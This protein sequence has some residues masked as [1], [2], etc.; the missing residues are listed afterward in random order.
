MR[1]PDFICTTMIQTTPC[2]ETSNKTAMLLAARGYRSPTC[3]SSVSHIAP[4][5]SRSKDSATGL[6]PCR[7]KEVYEFAYTYPYSYTKL[8]RW[9]HSWERLHLPYL[10][11]HLLCRT[12]Q[13]KRIDA[14][15]IEEILTDVG[16][17]CVLS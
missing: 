16:Q 4:K 13:M 10:Q 5:S 7:P 1:R 6:P 12:P 17:Y 14:V 9:L 15:V 8:Q 11:R 2:H 3:S